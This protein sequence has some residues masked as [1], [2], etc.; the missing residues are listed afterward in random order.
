MRFKKS[1]FEVSFAVD[2]WLAVRRKDT[3]EEGFI[4]GTNELGV[5]MF[6]REAPGLPKPLHREVGSG[7]TP[8]S[9][10]PPEDDCEQVV[11][12]ALPATLFELIVPEYE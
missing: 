12:E 7:R 5:V 3:G 4:H 10:L 9:N 1:D 8:E 2:R 11:V 6:Y